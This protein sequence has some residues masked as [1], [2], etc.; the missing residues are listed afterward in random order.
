M[1]AVGCSTGGPEALVTV[2][3]SPSA[4]V[5]APD[6]GRAA[7]AAG[8]HA[9][10]RRAAGPGMRA[11]GCGGDRGLPCRPWHRPRRAR[12][13]PPRGGRGSAGRRLSPGCSRSPPE[14]YCRPAVDVLFRSVANT[15][16]GGVLALVLTGMGSDGCLGAAEIRKANGEVLVQDSRTSV[17]WGMPGA[18]ADRGLAD[19]ILPLGSIASALLT[20]ANRRGRQALSAERPRIS[21]T[22]T[23]PT[24]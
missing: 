17:V 9:S 20:R 11:T 10:F 24:R 6:P 8:V 3:K 22:T 2:L 18:I 5:P 21:T 15:Y 7:H 1:L 16:K 23:R 14:N 4:D 13:F 12:R 19:E